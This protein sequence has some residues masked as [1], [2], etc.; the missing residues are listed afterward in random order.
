MSRK[1]ATRR[2]AQAATLD[3]LA[4]SYNVGISTF[5]APDET[6]KLNFG[7]DKLQEYFR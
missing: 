7:N 6:V 2:R 3:E 1:E 5:G 4:S